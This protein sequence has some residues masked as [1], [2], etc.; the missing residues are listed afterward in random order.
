MDTKEKEAQ[1]LASLRK[2]KDGFPKV[3]IVGSMQPT[4]RNDEGILILNV[5]DFLSGKAEI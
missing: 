2:I 5:Y 3:V 1:E 4:Y